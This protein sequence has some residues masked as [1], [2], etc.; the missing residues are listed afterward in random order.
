MNGQGKV[1]ASLFENENLIQLLTVFTIPDCFT[2]GFISIRD[3]CDGLLQSYISVILY[4][5]IM[6][7]ANI[8]S[9]MD[10]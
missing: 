10:F 1:N 7:C 9:I 5:F 8:T 6:F 4:N 2:K 3:G